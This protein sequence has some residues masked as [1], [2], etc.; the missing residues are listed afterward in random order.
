MSR[1]ASVS[2]CQVQLVHLVQDK[3]CRDTVRLA[4]NQETVNE[5]K[6]GLGL[7]GTQD[8]V[9]PIQVGRDDMGLT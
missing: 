7:G 8:D 2:V 9:C 5:G 6:R 1:L 4:G 3:C